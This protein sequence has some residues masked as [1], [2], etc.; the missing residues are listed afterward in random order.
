[1]SKKTAIITG[2][3]VL[4]L[5][6]GALAGY[7]ALKA[8]RGARNQGG[9]ATAPSV[10]PQRPIGPPPSLPPSVQPT[11]ATTTSSQSQIDTSN[12]KT[13]RNEKYGFELKYPGDW[14][15]NEHQN[16]STIEVKSRTKK[17]YYEGSEWRPIAI[18]WYRNL[19]KVTLNDFMKEIPNYGDE[20]QEIE[21]GGRKAIKRINYLGTF[22]YAMNDNGEIIYFELT[23]F[24]DPKI[25]IPLKKIFKQML[26]TVRFIRL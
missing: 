17:Y 10:Q 7:I 5:A 4:L 14:I 20:R 8:G 12:W 3:V 1:M 11:P 19:K 21:L 18:G 26:S 25:D 22:I 6:A 15:I 2:L 9:I 24:G 16:L 23:R 13:Y